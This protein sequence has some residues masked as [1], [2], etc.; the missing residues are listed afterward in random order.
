MTNTAVEIISWKQLIQLNLSVLNAS[1]LG[2]T[3]LIDF[4][5]VVLTQRH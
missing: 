3:F 1:G 4:V 5:F 2:V